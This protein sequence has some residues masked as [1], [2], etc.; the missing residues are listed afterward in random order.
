MPDDEYPASY[1]KDCKETKKGAWHR[2]TSSPGPLSDVT[3]PQ[4][5]IAL[6]LLTEAG[7]PF[8]WAIPF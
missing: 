2:L 8:S 6:V 4:Y 5:I 3:F 1:D 7:N